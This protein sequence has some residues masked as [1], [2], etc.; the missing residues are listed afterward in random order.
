[1]D[2][3][4]PEAVKELTEQ[5][6]R[7]EEALINNKPDLLSEFFWPDPLAIRYGV[8]E[9]LYG[10]REIADYRQARA[11]AGGVPKRTLT[12]T[13]ITAFGRKFGTSN[14]EYVRE[15][16]GKIGRQSQT[17]VRFSDRWRI[18]SAHVSPLQ[19]IDR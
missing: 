6:E 18:V 16:T 3:N 12:R 2:I 9:N 17:W 5:F 4:L 10:Y 8:A 14:T 7:Y 11:R 1:M 19:D 13:A 15:E